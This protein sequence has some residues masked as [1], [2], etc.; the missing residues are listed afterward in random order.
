MDK[1]S[2]NSSRDRKKERERER[3]REKKTE[4]KKNG[5]KHAATVAKLI[6]CEFVKIRTEF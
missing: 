6:F 5:N 2:I 4:S 3:K 1:L